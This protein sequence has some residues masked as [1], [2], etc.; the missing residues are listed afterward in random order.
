MKININ[1]YNIKLP[2][3]KIC[4]YT[5][6]NQLLI[7]K[8][9]C[10]HITFNAPYYGL[11]KIKITNNKPIY[12]YI[13]ETNCHTFNINLST[14][15]NTIK[16]IVTDKNYKNLKIKKGELKLWNTKSE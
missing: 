11:Y 8:S 5:N 12:I 7:E 9:N 6:N 16:V 4:I 10:A 2:K 1:I 13:T 3:Y 15:I 14:Q